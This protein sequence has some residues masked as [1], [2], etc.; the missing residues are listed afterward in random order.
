MYFLE[1]ER[2]NLKFGELISFVDA[3]GIQSGH[4]RGNYN[5]LSRTFSFQSVDGVNM[6]SISIM[7]LHDIQRG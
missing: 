5:K 1:F 3:N 6:Q 2:L 4:Y 7:K